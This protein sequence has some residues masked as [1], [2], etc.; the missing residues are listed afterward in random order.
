MGVFPK[1]IVLTT[2][3]RIDAIRPLYMKASLGCQ[4][5]S[6]R[7]NPRKC[8]CSCPKLHCSSAVAMICLITYSKCIEGSSHYLGD[9]QD[10]DVSSKGPSS[11][12]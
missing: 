6:L 8:C 1:T 7:E 3:P 10:F 9:K 12:N 4:N 5:N 2:K 11:G